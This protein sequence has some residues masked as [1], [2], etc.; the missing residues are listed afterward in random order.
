MQ[1]LLIVSA[2][3][4]APWLAS[5]SHADFSVQLTPLISYY[6]HR[7]TTESGREL[8]RQTGYLHGLNL[9]L[10]HSFSSRWQWHLS[11]KWLV[12]AVGYNG[13]TQAGSA[14]STSTR[15]DYRYLT[16]GLD[17]GLD[18]HSLGL[19]SQLSYYQRQRD[20]LPSA[21]SLPL[22]E[23]FTGWELRLGAEHPLIADYLWLNAGVIHSFKNQ[24]TSDLEH[25]GYGQPQL[26]LPRGWGGRAGL[27]L[28]LAEYSRWRSNLIIEYQ[29]QKTPR[30]DSVRAPGSSGAVLLVT[31]PESRL[32]QWLLGLSFSWH[33]V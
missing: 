28:R 29:Y 16:I 2:L 9:S 27:R 20:I 8:N 3:L 1:R 6:D 31:Q 24:L 11:G 32:Q 26:D 10:G 18:D 4:F 22:S 15:N 25:V 13:E 30:S 21:K 7:E 33:P 14:L 19:S 17:F 23:E 12:G 5:P